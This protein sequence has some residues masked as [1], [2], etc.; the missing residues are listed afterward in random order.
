MGAPGGATPQI[1]IPD[2]FGIL[3]ESAASSRSYITIKDLNI[4]GAGGTSSGGAE[5]LIEGK[6]ITIDNVEMTSPRNMMI[7]A[8]RA[9]SGSQGIDHIV[10]KN[11]RL[12]GQAADGNGYCIYLTANDVTIERNECYDVRGGFMQVYESSSNASGFTRSD[13]AIIRYNY[14]HDVLLPDPS[15]GI[16]S[17]FGIAID[18]LDDQVYG[19][20]IVDTNGVCNKG[21]MHGFKSGGNNNKIFNNLVTRFGRG[22]SM[23]SFV[24][25]TGHVVANNHLVGNGTNQCDARG[26]DAQGGCTQ[27][28]TAEVTFTTNRTTGV[29]GDC[30]TSYTDPRPIAGSSC[31]NQGT[32][33]AGFSYNGSAPDQ[34]PWESFGFSSASIDTNTMDVTL[35]MN[36]A[37]FSPVLPSS[38]QTTWTVAC[39][40]SNCGTPVVSSAVRLSGTDS[41][42]RL[43]ITGIGGGGNC[44]VGQT[45]TVTYAVG[46]V[47]DS[48]RIGGKTTFVQPMAAFATQGVTEVCTGSGTTP[49]AGPYIKYA[50]DEN[51][52]TT[53][54][55]TGS[56]GLN[57]TLAGGPTW[58]SGKAGGTDY[59][60]LFAG[61]NDESIT[62]G[63]GSGVNPSTQSL[64]MCLGVLPTSASGQKIVFSTNTTGTNQRFYIGWVGG[65]WG[66]GIQSSGFSSGSEFPVV[67]EWTRVCIVANSG[68][69]TATL[70][71]NG[72]KG[73][74]A[75][76]VKSY[77][78]YTL[79]NNFR[80]GNESSFSVN[81]CGCTVD[82][83]VLYQSALSDQDVADDF[84]A[85]NA[86]VP[87]PSG[88]FEQKT[89]KWQRLR[90]ATNGSAVDLTVSGST[91]G[92]TVTLPVGAAFGLVLQI[93]CTVANCDPTGLRI[94]YN[95]NG[96]T[97]F[98]VP[99][100]AGADGIAFY[101]STTDPDIVS[102]TVTCCLTGA[103]TTNDGST[104]FTASAVPVFDIGLN[105]SIVLRSVL[106]LSS[107]VTA[108]STYCFKGYH[109][110]DLVLNGGYT[111]SGGACVTVEA[112]AI[113]VGF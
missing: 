81:Y 13:R 32:A 27:T 77:T 20:I 53:A 92:I 59:G 42:V 3:D 55:D 5:L 40:G 79:A 1:N 28:S 45:W 57:G 99:D 62:M 41:V 104:Q 98:A 87:T 26:N 101:G 102:G 84:S 36:V 63:Y 23:N 93:D 21:I 66:I 24:L 108:G 72:A 31:I 47:T 37:S 34:G 96:G 112:L 30:V 86:S 58:A 100:T 70:Y 85:W 4:S 38:G 46:T 7:A 6:F 54:T 60:V 48:A 9:A 14:M 94:Y 69:D 15:T 78:S 97:F 76:A 19:N 52:G 95:L 88:T 25:N 111:P 65:T 50:L 49:P 83:F 74:T 12:H 2:W 10:I 68:T 89:H 67:A 106:K 105:A 11:S 22:V 109:Q 91:N 43:T 18:G 8:F 64:S 73:A 113:G 56:A 75:Q 39:S 44:A 33:Q 35:G 103:L 16:N 80:I 82:S 90:K 29:I 107:S 61:T 71:V 110:T 17:C 51:T